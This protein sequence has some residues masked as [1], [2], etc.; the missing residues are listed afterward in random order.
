MSERPITILYVDDEEHNLHS[1]KASFRKQYSITVASSVLEAEQILEREDFCIILADQRMPIMTGVQF[2]EKIRTK[3]PKPIRILITGHTDIGAA[4]DAINKG[5]VFRFIDK[6]WDYK[7]VEN[8]IS[9]AYDIYKT[10]EDLKQRNEE[11][12]KANEELDK[13]VYS[14]SHDLRSPLTSILGLLAF[15]ESESTEPDTIK[16]AEMIRTSVNRLD[17][18]IKNILSYS[19]NSRTGVI[20]QEIALHETV[21]DIV[22]SLQ[23]MKE[24]T[25]IR[26]EINIK[27]GQPFYTDRIRLNTILENLISNAIKYHKQ[28]ASERYIKVEGYSDNENLHLTVMD[29]GIGIEA[30][31]HQK[32]YEMFFRLS[33]KKEG[34]GIGLYIVKEAIEKLQGSI[35]IESE[36][37]TGTTFTIT[38]KNFKS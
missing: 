21:T 13:F 34:S 23:R 18:F 30:A 38:L 19:R 31:Y 8:A 28:E 6:P 22:G 35:E 20:V 27:Q 24:A 5:E 1:F 16:H 11:L 9:H 17:E 29:N 7:Y 2:F 3:Y 37:G 36:E 15:I 10:R 33:S 4:I 25:G 26:Y 32:I 14:V 12:Q